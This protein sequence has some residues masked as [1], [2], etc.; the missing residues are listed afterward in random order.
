M[1]IMT[2][3]QPIQS[4][5]WLAYVLA[6]VMAVA[7]IAVYELCAGTLHAFPFLLPVTAVTIVA[8]LG[9][10]GPAILTA[11]LSELFI[12]YYVLPPYGFALA[13]PSGYIGVVFY[14]ALCAII[15][16]LMQGMFVAHAALQAS[17]IS[18]QR[19]N[20]RLEQRVNERTATIVEAQSALL[21]ANQNLERIVDARVGDL[22]LANEEIQ[23][24]AYIVSHDL[25]APLVN[26]LGFTSE[27]EAVRDD[28]VVFLGDVEKRAP[29]LVTTDRRLA[30]DTDIPEALGFIR[31]STM[32]MDRLIN[33]IL[34]LSREGRR[35]LNPQPIDISALVT[36]QGE[37]LAQQ[38]AARQAKLVI[39][40]DLPPLVSDKLAIE[41]IFGNLIENAVKYLSRDRPGHIEVTGR[42]DGQLLRYDIIDNGRGISPNDFERIFDLFR[43]SGEQD[44]PGEGIGLSYVRNLVRR[45]GGNVTVQ[46]D[47]GVGST[48]SV[49]LPSTFRTQPNE[50]ALEDA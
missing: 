35:K 50:A 30:I 37:T 29:D 2:I 34:R 12:Q 3:A 22:K 21:D 1:N 14:T 42:V 36:A 5:S 17:E 28:L 19:L 40:G 26:V 8:F 24:F 15:I 32:K 49:T 20:D 27:L 25:R 7:G 38:L 9:G 4:R 10:R 48:F 46:S 47:Y 31:S 39:T 33:A 43:R 23:R 41:Q 13:W 6:V 44:T 16:F 18:L 45:L 11:I